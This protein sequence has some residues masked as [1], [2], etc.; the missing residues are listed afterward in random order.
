MLTQEIIDKFYK[1]VDSL[2]IKKKGAVITKATG[3]SKSNV[4]E[5]LNKVKEPSE[6]FIAAF[7]ENFG[8]LLPKS[9]T[10]VPGGQKEDMPSINQVNEDPVEYNTILPLGELKVTLKEYVDLLKET[11]RKAEERERKLL[12]ILEKNVITIKANSDAILDDLSQVVRMVRA[13]DM[14]MMD[15]LDRIEGREPGRTRQEAGIVERAYEAEDEDN[16]TNDNEHKDGNSGK[17][18]KQ[19]S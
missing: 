6:N 10:E 14:A 16:G 2:N 5:Y 12:L 18:K 8:A 15:S 17:Q 11:A 7:Y 9:S 3:F 1:D 13:D 4:S 19:G